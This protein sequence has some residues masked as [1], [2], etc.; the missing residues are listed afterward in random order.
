MASNTIIGIP[1]DDK[2]FEENC[3]T[4]FAGILNDP[5]VKLVGTRGAG[6]SGLDLIGR[7]NRDPNQPVGIQCKLITRGGKLGPAMVRD[8]VKAALAYSPPLTEYYIVTT[9]RDDPALDSLALELSQEQAKLGR[10]IDIQIW[11]WDTLQPRIRRNPDALRA[12]DPDY[13]ASTNRLTELGEEIAQSQASLI[14]QSAT[15][16]AGLGDVQVT[17]REIMVDTERSAAFD[18]HLDAQVDEYRDLMNNGKPRT[19]LALLEKLDASLGAASSAAI[20]ARVRVNMGFAHLRLDNEAKAAE[21]IGQGYVINPDDPRVRA[22]RILALALAGDRTEA[23]AFAREVIS[24]EPDNSGAAAMLYQVAAFH[25]VDVDADSIVPEV[26]RDEKTV[27][28]ARLHYLRHKRSPETW[29]AA[30]LDALAVHPDEGSAMRMAGEA[31]VEQALGDGRILTATALTDANLAKLLEGASLLQRHWDEVREYE[32]AADPTW[33]VVGCNLI[34]AYRALGDLSAARR[35]RDQLLALGDQSEEARLAAAQLAVD[36]EN[37]AEVVRL[38]TGLPESRAR[39]MM[40]LVSWT[41]AEDWAAVLDFATPERRDALEAGDRET[42]DVMRFRAR[43]ASES[44]FD[45]ETE[46]EAL[47]ASW[48][49]GIAAHIAVTDMYRKSAPDLVER[50]AEKTLSLLRADASFAHRL[51]FAQ[52]SMHRGAWNDVIAVLDGFVSTLHASEPLEWL[53][54]AF[55]NAPVRARTR[56]FFRSL[57]APLIESSKFA[58][59]AGAAEYHRG[60][61]KM[62]ARHLRAAVAD[63]PSDL[64]AH[65]LLVS[66]L[67][68]DADEAGAKTILRAIDEHAV[69]GA[70]EDRMRLAILLRRHGH[71]ERALAL[72]YRTAALNRDNEH[73][74]ASYPPL[75][76]FDERLPAAVS[77]A[78]RVGLG[79]WFSVAGGNTADVAGVIDSELLSGAPGFLPTH[80][81]ASLLIG[82]SVGE[83][84]TLEAEFGP[85]RSYTVTEIKHKYIWLLHDIM[86]THA[87]RFPQATSLVQVTMRE[88][89]VQPVLDMVRGME[90][91]SRFLTQTY[92]NLAV[93]VA[94]VAAMAK[95]PVIGLVEHLSATGTAM[96]TCHG[97]QEERE[98]AAQLVDR[99]RGK[100]AVL[101]T[102][103]FYAAHR[104][105][106]LAGLRD[107]FG[108][109]AIPRSTLDELIEM[110]GSAE[111]NRGREYMTMGFEGEQAWRR[112]HTPE[113]TEAQIAAI[114]AL[115][116]AAQLH[117]DVLATDGADDSRFARM[118]DRF[119]A[120]DIADPFI[121]AR[122]EAMLLLSDDLTLRTLAAQEAGVDGAW[123]QVALRMAQRA[124]TMTEQDFLRGVGILA[125]MRHDHVWLDAGTLRALLTGE[126]FGEMWFDSALEFIGGKKADIDSH[127]TVVFEFLCTIWSTALPHWQ[128]G[129][130]C[131]Q[132]L[133]KL[134]RGRAEW[135]AVLHLLDRN[136]GIA[137]R[138]GIAGAI[139]ARQ[140]VTDWIRGH[141]YDLDE[142]RSAERLIADARAAR[143]IPAK[144]GPEGKRNRREHRG[145]RR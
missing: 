71:T 75:I 85:N 128:K 25:D 87:A 115:I 105:G 11:G 4:L 100:G 99:Y 83:Q 60:D 62:A 127:L 70:P 12:F 142:I 143:S 108:R 36:E 9:A 131:G 58:R 23:V 110:R 81:L 107:Y 28:L 137:I 68:R 92:E 88:G 126:A 42:I 125:A 77:R 5:N 61:L 14:E 79:H 39:T 84:A 109:L 133:D 50:M 117:C 122:S 78:E 8:E 52:L 32:N 57:A 132:L 3:I 18:A 35:T 96:R 139:P 33:A 27:R 103:T 53:A 40:L 90:E 24:S 112:V 54:V 76:F 136:L 47:L 98:T 2:V 29:R 114:T 66:T 59:L 116:D 67:E 17:L 111:L 31:L 15:I 48:P 145:A 138:R 74:V 65:L 94:A 10:V 120:S 97:S 123:L 95:K 140:Y 1:T 41:H 45:V 129:R 144:V 135:K 86:E 46:V 80:P 16:S 38:L 7:R 124:G 63:D 64:R 101:D 55:A 26:Q 37:A 73:V 44:S 56:I 102:L 51:M 19:A 130:A 30:A 43:H 91:R 69:S 119:G 49:L 20:R 34:T 89:D 13:S 106:V 113:D 104:I 118:M 22:N 93:P 141:F 121:I 134:L 72:G 21:L 82:K 6:Q